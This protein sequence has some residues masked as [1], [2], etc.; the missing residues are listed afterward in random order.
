MPEFLCNNLVFEK[1]IILHMGRDVGR[2]KFH[3]RVPPFFAISG[4]SEAFQ[5]HTHLSE[6][7]R[8]DIRG[9]AGDGIHAIFRGL[10]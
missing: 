1:I 5:R 6:Q 9:M 3:E 2:K 8:P 4:F 10:F 7:G